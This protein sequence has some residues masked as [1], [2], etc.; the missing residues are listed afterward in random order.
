MKTEKKIGVYLDHAQAHFINF[1]HESEN[2]DAINSDFD[3]FE[4]EKSLSKSESGMHSKEQQDLS[5]FF[6]KIAKVIM[7]YDDVLLFGPTD[8]KVEL[9]NY[10]RTEHEYDKIKMEVKNTD[11]LT[12][13]QKLE[14][15]KNHFKTLLNYK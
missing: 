11:K 4:K 2:I 6:R 10:L 3:H 14:F 5:F 12:E 9:F 8:A 13:N 7:N 15:V 1:Q